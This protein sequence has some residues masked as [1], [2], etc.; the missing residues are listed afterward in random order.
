MKKLMLLLLLLS[1][2]AQATEPKFHF[3]DCVSIQSG[4]YKGCHG[5]VQ[6]ILHQ[7]DVLLTHDIYDVNVVCKSESIFQT[8]KESELKLSPGS[9]GEA[10]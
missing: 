3:K 8:F 9:C 5:L 1:I 2:P 7:A 6:A 10:Q 4:F